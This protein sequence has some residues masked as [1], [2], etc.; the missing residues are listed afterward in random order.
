MKKKN[1]I[2]RAAIIV[3]EFVFLITIFL[4]IVILK[5]NATNGLDL[6][7]N[8]TL[9]NLPVKHSTALNNDQSLKIRSFELQS[10]I[11]ASSLKEIRKMHVLR[12]LLNNYI[13][14]KMYQRE[15]D[16]YKLTS[17][18]NILSQI[19]SN[20]DP[21]IYQ[22]LAFSEFVNKNSEDHLKLLKT[23][24]RTDMFKPTLQFSKDDLKPFNEYSDSIPKI[25]ET[26]YHK[27]LA[28]QIIIKIKKREY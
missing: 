21:K 5:A 6:Y 16:A 7:R 23:V 9:S 22:D 14:E 20:G 18:R 17:I 3:L 28:P 1:K 8:K 10:N 13:M 4:G 26:M 15:I 2:K 24:Y 12:K 25:S 27:N 11:K 19:P